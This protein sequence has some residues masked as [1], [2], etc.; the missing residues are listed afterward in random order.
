M[1]DTKSILNS[2]PVL[3]YYENYEYRINGCNHSGYYIIN[4]DETLFNKFVIAC[5]GKPPLT[6]Y[7][8]EGLQDC[9]RLNGGGIMMS[10]AKTKTHNNYGCFGYHWNNTL[11]DEQREILEPYMHLIGPLI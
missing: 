3:K 9:F 10:T 1:S 5:R 11:G 4:K 8:P 7:W 2:I 6:N